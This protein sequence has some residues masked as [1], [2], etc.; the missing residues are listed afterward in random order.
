MS[1]GLALLVFRLRPL[2]FL[3]SD[4]LVHVHD[5]P[6]VCSDPTLYVRNHN[7][8]KSLNFTLPLNYP[9]LE[10]TYSSCH[11]V[12]IPPYCINLFE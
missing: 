7:G 5:S 3:V 1:H 12:L 6:L 4:D 8:G 10:G 2:Y 9:P 11:L